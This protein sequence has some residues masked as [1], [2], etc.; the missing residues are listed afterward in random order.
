MP[1]PSHHK[2]IVTA[3]VLII[4]LLAG[5]SIGGWLLRVLVL[6]AACLGLYEFFALAGPENTP[7][8]RKIGFI[9]LGGLLVLSQA[10]GPMMTL[11]L[12]CLCFCVLG[13]AFLFDFGLGNEQAKL[14]EYA[15]FAFGL[16]YIPLILQLALYLTPSEQ[17]LVILAAVASDTGGYYAGTLWG[18]RKLWPAV[19][20]KKSWAGLFG[21]LALCLVVCTTQGLVGNSLGWGLPQMPLW[22]WLLT[23]LLLHQAALFGDFFESALKRTLDVKDSGS[24]L[25]G[26]GGILDRIDSILFTIPVYMAI[27][28]IA[29]F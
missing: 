13:M 28:L 6:A 8:P 20:P 19:S 29:L 9:L 22:A 12:L 2:R 1:L 24:L 11:A 3:L 16:L 18:K 10:G 26:H 7:W 4:V 23:A 21:G 17:S 27:R 14:N 15:P 5:I 25:P